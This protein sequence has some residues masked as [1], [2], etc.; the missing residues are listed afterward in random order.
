MGK[1][2]PKIVIILGPTASGKTD[3]ALALAKK[4]N[5]EIINADSKQIYRDLDIGTAKGGV[6]VQSSKFKIMVSLSDIF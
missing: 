4:F 2:K 1:N 6:K 5:G 3:M